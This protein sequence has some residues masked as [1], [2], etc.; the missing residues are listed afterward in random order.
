MNCEE[1][2]DLVDA[3]ALGAL[4]ESEQA[5]VDAHLQSCPRC[6]EL[7]ADA[8]ALVTRL[9][10]SLPLRRAPASLRRRVLS[11]IGGTESDVGGWPL[12]QDAAGI[13]AE[14]HHSVPTVLPFRTRRSKP[15]RI[16]LVA[17]AV[18]A[19]VFVAMAGWIIGLQLQV[20]RLERSAHTMQ[21]NMTSLEGQRAALMLLASQGSTTLSMD[22]MPASNG[23]Q[24]IVIWNPQDG[25]CDVLAGNLPPLPAGSSYHVWMM[26][27]NSQNWD[28]GQLTPGS[29]GTAQKMLDLHRITNPQDY[30]VLITVQGEGSVHTWKPVLSAHL[31]MQPKPASTSSN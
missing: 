4:S 30:S 10:L 8:E 26:G 11:S 15:S 5:V 22:A 19:V 25:R 14:A 29:D 18:A 9:N 24:A 27:A 12:G 23:A 28:S 2:A 13:R 3:Y 17:G 20:N 7:E 21:R 1:I 31:A 16:Q 6:R